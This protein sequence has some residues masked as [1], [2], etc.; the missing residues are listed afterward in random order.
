MEKEIQKNYFSII[1]PLYNKE[2]YIERAIQSIL[3]QSY[4]YFEIIIVNDGSIDG[5]EKEVLKINDDRITLVNQENKGVSVARNKGVETA[6][7]ELVTFLDADDIWLNNFLEELNLLVNKYPLVSV[8]GLNNYFEML[9]GKVIYDDFN[10]LFNGDIDGIINNYFDLFVKIG[11]SPF[12]NSN[13]CIQKQLFMNEGGYKVGVKLT[14]YSDFW[15]RLALKYKIAFLIKPLATYF[16]GTNGSTH[17]LFE[18]DDFQV[19]KTLK[20]AM[21]LNKVKPKFQ[22]SVIKLIVF[23]EMSLIKRSILTGNRKFALKKLL[24][25]SLFLNYPINFLVIL[26]SALIPTRFLLEIKNK[27]L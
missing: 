21:I 1:I 18:S 8:Y 13:F 15:C 2:E 14:E 4:Q 16:I 20:S 22:K 6:K 23:Q 5:G 12:S 7:Y 24:K 3:I 10:W 11:R 9:N 19:T 25:I 27:Y 17:L 26:I